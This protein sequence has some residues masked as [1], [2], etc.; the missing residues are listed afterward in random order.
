MKKKNKIKEKINKILY[1]YIK[2]Q[3]Y[4]VLIVLA[5]N[6]IMTIINVNNVIEAEEIPECDNNMYGCT[7][8]VY[9]G[10][11]ITEEE[12]NNR[13]KR[14]QMITFVGVVGFLGM[15][16]FNPESR[17]RIKGAFKK[18]EIKKRK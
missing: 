8:Y 5:F 6:I 15:I 12:Y 17:E 13:N 14:M 11:L 1:H 4:I 7:N 2:I 10:E 18:N 9:N 3:I 16:Y